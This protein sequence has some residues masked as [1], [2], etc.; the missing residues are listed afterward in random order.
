MTIPMLDLAAHHRE[1]RGD[2]LAAATEVIDSNRFILGPAVTELEEAIAA[3][4]QCSHG[5]GVSSGTDALLIALMALGIGPGDEVVTTPYSFFA[6]AGVIARLGARPVFADIDPVTY[7]IDPDHAAAVVTPRTRAIIAVHLYGQCADMAP[8]LAIAERHGIPVIED[9][10]QAI[11]S[12]YRDGRRA[13]S[14]GTSG[15]FSFFPSKN[16][17]AIGDAG[18]VVTNDADHAEKV[19]ILRVHGSKPK[20]YHQIIGGNFRI[21]ELQAALLLVKQR[22]LDNWTRKRQQNAALY[23][24]GFEAAS[25]TGEHVI[26]PTAVYQESGVSHF[27]IYN[28]FIL[29]VTR[30]DALRDFLSAHGVASEIYYPVPFHL[31]AC[32]AYLDYRNGAFPHAEAAARETVAIPIYPELTPTQ[33]AYV[34]EQFRT[35]Y[36]RA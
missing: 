18:M 7:N 30:R 9:A 17:G 12:E 33:I 20:Y 15:C 25:V 6:T 10:A 5:V 36:S 32:F 34:V 24:D 26:L 13:G 14:M 19:R 28:Q 4:S 35:F 8:L 1:I 11:G 23:R 16:L 21:D 2:L 22:H 27:H 29:R 31:Q 3:Y